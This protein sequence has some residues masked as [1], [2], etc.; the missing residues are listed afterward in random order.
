MMQN[1]T[2]RVKAMRDAR[3][4]L[5]SYDLGQDKSVVYGYDM[6]LWESDAVSPNFDC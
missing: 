4:L 5:D 6:L 1:S 3:K 2:Y